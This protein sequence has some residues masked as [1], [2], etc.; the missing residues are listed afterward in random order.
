MLIDWAVGR[1]PEGGDVQRSAGMFPRGGW[2][3]WHRRDGHRLTPLGVGVNDQDAPG[4]GLVLKL[5][6]YRCAL[7]CHHTP[8]HLV[9]ARTVIWAQAPSRPAGRASA[10]GAKRRALHGAEHRSS[11]DRVMA[12]A[13][14]VVPIDD[15]TWRGVASSTSRGSWPDLPGRT[16]PHRP[17]NLVPISAQCQLDFAGLYRLEHRPADDR[18]RTP[19]AMA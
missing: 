7:G 3:L 9:V 4:S 8:G 15:N 12:G 16:G 19:T 10:V 18:H 6:H 11:I 13:S 5:D 2:C 17:D 14:A 1:G